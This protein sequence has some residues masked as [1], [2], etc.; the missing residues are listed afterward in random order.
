[1]KRYNDLYNKICSFENLHLAYLKARKAKRYKSEILKFS[2]YLESN[3]LELQDELLNQ[4]YKHG[5]YKTFVV[6]DSKKR[7]IKAAS[8]KDRVVHH[9]LCNIIEPIFDRGFIYDS[10]ACRRKKGTHKT[11]KRL[12]FF[13]RSA[14]DFARQKRELKNIYCL[15][16][17]IAKYFASID[18]NILISLIKKKIKDK[19]VLWLIK[20]ILESSYEKKLF[21]DLFK[22]RLIGIPI[23]NLTSQLFANIYLNR[24]DQFIK[25]Q[26]RVRYYIRYMDDFLILDSDKNLLGKM[27][28]KIREFLED[29]LKLKLHPKKANVFPI[30]KGIDFLGYRTFKDY[31]LLRKSTVKRFVKRTRNYKNKVDK[32]LISE[33]KLDRS[34]QSW[35]AYARFANSWRLSKRIKQKYKDKI[36]YQR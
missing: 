32:G 30:V 33:E 36:M 28:F 9:A 23:G 24:L 13:I 8:F 18:H 21:E 31:K 25:H 19:K 27:K 2:Y 10:Y 35:F 7:V 1:M 6:N 22:F 4:T 15:Q 14:S 26:L 34:I 5:S 20:R 12:D 17:D 16:C 11:I 29:K 3:L